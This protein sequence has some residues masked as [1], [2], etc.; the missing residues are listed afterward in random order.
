MMRLRFQTIQSRL[1]ICLLVFFLGGTWFLVSHLSSVTNTNQQQQRKNIRKESPENIRIDKQILDRYHVDTISKTSYLDL[2]YNPIVFTDR[3]PLLLAEIHE[4]TLKHPRPNFQEKYYTHAKPFLIDT[5][6]G[7]FEKDKQSRINILRLETLRRISL[8]VFAPSIT[9]RDYVQIMKLLAFFDG[10]C[11]RNDFSYMMYGGTLLGSYRHHDLV[12]WDDDI[13]VLVGHKHKQKLVEILSNLKPNF[14]LDTYNSLHYK[15]Y[16][17]TATFRASGV[18]W[19]W[20]YLDIT[21]YDENQTHIWDALIYGGNKKRYIFPKSAVFPLIKRPFGVLYLPSPR[22]VLDNLKLT[23]DG[24]VLGCKTSFYSHKLE[25]AVSLSYIIPC[26]E[27]Y[28]YY[29]FVQRDRED[30]STERLVYKG[31]VLKTIEIQ[32]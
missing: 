28:E 13:D 26:S 15:L 22:L 2:P 12:P 3:N 7:N 27:L 17:Q 4:I 11:E 14:I 6:D 30:A 24:E 5:N 21:F 32:K 31:K 23:Y 9:N 19:L 29:P 18:P 8:P 20:P 25:M 16:A 1:V 10:I